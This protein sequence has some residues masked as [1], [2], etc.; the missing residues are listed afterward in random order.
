MT[1]WISPYPR[2]GQYASMDH[3]SN[4][5]TYSDVILYRIFG[6]KPDSVLNKM[7]LPGVASRNKSLGWKKELSTHG[8]SAPFCRHSGV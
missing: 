1:V 3:Y 6:A 7:F 4:C 5:A 2:S 8:C